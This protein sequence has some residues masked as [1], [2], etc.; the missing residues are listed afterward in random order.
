MKRVLLLLLALTAVLGA[1]YA[2]F[3]RTSPEIN[4][5]VFSKTESFRHES[6]PAG[7]QAIMELG[8]KHGFSVDTTEDASVFVEDQLKNYN[9]L[10]FLNTTGDVLNDAQQLEMNRFIQAGGGYVGI[11]AAADTEYEWEWYGKL[12]GAYFNGHPNDPNVREAS[13]DR[14]N[15][16]HISTEHLPDRWT[17]TD[18]WYNFKAIQP[19]LQVLL[20]LDETSYEGGTNGDNHPIAWYHDFDGGRAWYTGLGHTIETFTEPDFLT[21]LW[22]GIQ[23]AA[24]PGVPVNFDNASVSPEENRFSKRVLTSN[25]N[26]PM[27]LDLLPDGNILFVERRGDLHQYNP[28]TKEL[29]TI[30]TL[31]VY[32]THEDGLLGLAIDPNYAVNHWIYLFYSPPGD[33]AKQHVSRFVFENGALD[34]TSEKV[35]LEIATQREECCH[36]AG[37]LEFGPD[38]LLFIS[39]GDN[40]NPHASDGFSPSDERAGRSPWDAQKSSA[41]TQDLRGKVLRIKPEADGTYSIPEGNLFDKEGETGRP[42]I[43]VMGCRNPYRISIDKRTGYL[44]WGDV[45]PDAGDPMDQRGPAGHD[46]VNQARQAG[47]FGWPYFVGDNKAYFE[48]DFE[49]EKTLSQ[50]DPNAPIN[51]SPNNTGA[52]QLPPAQSAFI[53][54]PY[55]ESSDF[56]MVG[57]GGRNAMAGPVF[58]VADYPDSEARYPAYYDGK[59]FAYDW[60]RGWIMAVTMNEAGDFVRMERFLPSFTF[61]NPVDL[62]MSPAGDMYMLEYGSNWFSQNE[63]ARLVHLEYVAGNRT[64][65]ARIAASKTMGAAPME[66]QFDGKES[67]DFDGDELRYEWTFSDLGTSTEAQPTFVFDQPGS[68]QIQLTVTD[69]EGETSQTRTELLVGNEP[70][71]LAWEFS[72]NQSFYFEGQPIEYAV[73]VSDAEDGTLGGGISPAKVRVSID[74]LERGWDQTEAAQ[75][76]QALADASAASVGAQLME[77]SDCQAC[78]QLN[79]ASIGPNYEAIAAKYAGD[80]SARDYLANKIIK[81]GGGVWGETVMAAHPQLSLNEAEKMAEYILSLDPSAA[82]ASMPLQGTYAF[83]EHEGKG[84][85][86]AYIFTAS[87]TDQGS[88]EIRPLTAQKVL[89]LRAP[90]ISAANFAETNSAMKFEITPDMALPGMEI[91][92]AFW[93]MLGPKGAFVK[94]D[95][96]DLTGIG[97]IEV[98][99]TAPSAFMEGGKVEVRID[100]PEGPKIGEWEFETTLTPKDQTFTVSLESVKGRHPLYL[101]FVGEEGKDGMVGAVVTLRF[102]QTSGS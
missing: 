7:K 92:E 83:S 28:A 94:Y 34:M 26:E 80:A 88:G 101:V 12:V 1:V 64:P 82:P 14:L 48:Y 53:W 6:I 43:Y 21:H 19:D 87:Y 67:V 84:D 86:G 31:K 68:Y 35:L 90:I 75:G 93:L 39:V 57:N 73:Q 40:T 79:E 24:G 30:A 69:P 99:G 70:P 49:A 18:E 33:E 56:P 9:V 20:N 89:T 85:A 58:H 52:E 41:N 60:M 16:E 23:Y 71:Q 27:E 54:Y 17:R 100:E 97:S 50:H 51:N 77:Q 72:G 44:Y 66:V 47:F 37:S 76:H 36:S 42:E 65:V 61:N 8:T 102:L 91:E 81:G 78:H 15:A 4:V 96:L 55:S 38:G 2:I 13:I 98:V 74:Y 63:D 22:G 5:L 3:F 10:I 11:H 46:E 25:L 62:L 45:G 95:D 59:L 29:L 32:S